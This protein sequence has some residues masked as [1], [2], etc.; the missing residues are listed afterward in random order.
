V[1]L[2]INN[3]ISNTTRFA[4]DGVVRIGFLTSDRVGTRHNVIFQREREAATGVLG[5]LEISL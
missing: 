3:I 2:F 4:D 5:V 1:T